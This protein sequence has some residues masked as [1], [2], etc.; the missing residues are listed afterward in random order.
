MEDNLLRIFG[1]ERI[2]NVIK[3]FNSEDD[4]P[5]ESSLL[6]NNLDSAQKKVESFS[7]D[8]RKQ[9]F[10]YDE[11]LTSQRNGIYAERKRIIENENLR[12]WVI[13]YGERSLYDIVSSREKVPP[14]KG[15]SIENPSTK[16]M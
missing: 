8:A 16:S 13:E 15:I 7:Y 9:L 2:A 10:E 3:N 14:G 12:D 11:A 5:L 1:G 6:T 4:L